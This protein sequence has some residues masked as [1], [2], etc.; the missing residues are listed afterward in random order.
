[1]FIN[2]SVPTPN[3]LNT[4]KDFA[5]IL[6]LM[7]IVQKSI[8]RV[9][10][11]E[12]IIIALILPMPYVFRLVYSQ[13]KNVASWH[14]SDDLRV[15]GPLVNLGS[16]ELGAYL[17]TCTLLLISLAFF[18]EFKR[19]WAKYLTYISLFCAGT[20]LALTFSRGAYLAII[21]AGFYFYLIK[22]KKGK[23]T[24]ILIV[25]TLSLPVIMPVS[26]V[27]R[28]TSIGASED[29]RDKSASSRFEFWEVAF[30][31]TAESPIVGWGYRSWQS[32]EINSTGMDTH[33]YFVKIM[34]EGGAIGL[35]LVIMLLFSIYK[36]SRKNYKLAT[37][38]VHKSIA[39]AVLLST[40]GL[41]IGNMFGD[42]F[43]HYSVIFI[44]W[45]MV[46]ILI[47]LDQLTQPKQNINK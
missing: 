42:R 9:E 47:K 4:L 25:F 21:L 46:G 3:S 40:I 13:Y 33:N 32:S 14:Y 30:D 18:F 22:E 43:S 45:T 24:A 44:Y 37:N 16:N 6:C 35:L 39:L 10:D 2:L 8:T 17:V 11:V 27:E 31:K 7:Y 41:C 5:L 38:S 34:V 26:V 15:N 19:N 1:M 20:S 23:L 36:L 28:F 29:T 12:K